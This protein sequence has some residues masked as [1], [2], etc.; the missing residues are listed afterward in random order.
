MDDGIQEQLGVAAAA[1]AC[2]R[3]QQTETPVHHT[4]VAAVDA[5]AGGSHQHSANSAAAAARRD[6]GH[7]DHD[8]PYW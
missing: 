7:W 6:W 5:A 8:Q 2:E 3:P 1:D 4:A